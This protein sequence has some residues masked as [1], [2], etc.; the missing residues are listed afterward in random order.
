LP[1]TVAELLRLR[2]VIPLLN[3]SGYRHGHASNGSG[4]LDI[5]WLNPQG[6]PMTDF[7]WHHTH[8]MAMVLA[9]TGDG[10]ADTGAVA[11]LLNA[12][13]GPVHFTLPAWSENGT[14]KLLF[15]SADSNLP[16]PAAQSLQ[17]QD[18]SMALLIESS[19]LKRS[20]R[21]PTL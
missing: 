3:Q 6:E 7:D 12:A 19:R 1:E 9:N 10:E 5:E 14:W 18:R 20:Q 17:L 4:R 21:G 15:T 13:E 16:Q 2:R 8:A 11:I